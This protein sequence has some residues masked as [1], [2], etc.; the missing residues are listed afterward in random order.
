M[1]QNIPFVEKMTKVVPQAVAG[2]INASEKN[3]VLIPHLTPKDLT[4]KRFIVHPKTKGKKGP[5]MTLRIDK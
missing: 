1:T 2:N 4:F 3:K 5:D